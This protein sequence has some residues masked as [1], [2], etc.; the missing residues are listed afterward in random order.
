M[1][2]WVFYRIRQVNDIQAITNSVRPNMTA[3]ATRSEPRP[4]AKAENWDKMTATL[5]VYAL[6]ANF[7]LQFSVDEASG[8]TVI[9]VINVETQQIIR[10]IPPEASLKVAAR[11]QQMIEHVIDLTV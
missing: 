9:K 3:E 8:K 5:E 10:I 7:R 1:N 2:R 11:L 4:Q 6:Q